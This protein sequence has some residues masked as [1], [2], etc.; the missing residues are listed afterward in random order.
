MMRPFG[1]H[2]SQDAQ[3][4]SPHLSS[5]LTAPGYPRWPRRGLSRELLAG[6]S[7]VEARE[8]REV[9]REAREA[10]E[11]LDSRELSLEGT[12]SSSSITCS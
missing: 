8:L 7:S 11:A 4:L 6:V 2:P 9:P 12:P 10:R 1:L 5:Y 3:P